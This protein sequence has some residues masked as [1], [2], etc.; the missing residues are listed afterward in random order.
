M[1]IKRLLIAALLAGLPAGCASRGTPLFDAHSGTTARPHCTVVD[2][3]FGGPGE[4]VT[5]EPVGKN[6]NKTTFI[7]DK[8]FFAIPPEWEGVVFVRLGVRGS[9]RIKVQMVAKG[10]RPKS[11]YF[12]L[13][14]EGTYYVWLKYTPTFNQGYAYD[15]IGVSWDGGKV[16]SYRTR[17]RAPRGQRRDERNKRWF[18]DRLASEKHLKAGKHAVTITF[19]DAEGVRTR[20]GQRLAGLWV[21]N[22][23]SFVPPG[24]TVQVMFKAP[25]P[26][27]P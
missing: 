20:M 7:N 10:R 17:P 5:G 2:D 18:H 4:V 11:Y 9:R 13:P 25:T 21:T 19:R 1:M 12:E 3:P 14:A 27:V 8:G 26:W 22:D 23:A 6:A 24:Y 15:S 16:T